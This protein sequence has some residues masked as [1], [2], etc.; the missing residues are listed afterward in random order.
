VEIVEK[1]Q[2]VYHSESN[3]TNYYQLF[4]KLLDIFLTLATIILLAFTNLIASIKFVF[5]LYPRTI[6]IFLFLYFIFFYIVDHEKIVTLYHLLFFDENSIQF[7]QL[8]HHQ[9]MQQLASDA[10]LNNNNDIKQNIF[11]KTWKTIYNV[12]FRLEPNN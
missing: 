7:Q 4:Y 12:F 10:Y 9:K 1:T 8:Q 3:P 2:K 11:K 6:V 5:L